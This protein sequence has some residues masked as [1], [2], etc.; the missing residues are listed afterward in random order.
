MAEG[1]LHPGHFT[2]LE[3]LH[4]NIHEFHDHGTLGKLCQWVLKPGFK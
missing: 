4:E 2:R 1:S 3:A